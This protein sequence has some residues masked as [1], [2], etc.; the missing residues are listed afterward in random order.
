MVQFDVVY[1]QFPII[2]IPTFLKNTHKWREPAFA[3]LIVAM[4]MLASRYC[5]DPRVRAEPDNPTSAGYHYFDLFR[6]LRD[7]ASLDGDDPVE[8][9][10]ALF[11]AA[12]YHCV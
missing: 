6:E 4:C 1:P 3:A 12:F 11:C 9:C 8:A 7:M 10:Q 2:H 5:S